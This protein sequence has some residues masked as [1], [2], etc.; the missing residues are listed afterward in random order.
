MA[1]SSFVRSWCSMYSSRT[2]SFVEIIQAS[3]SLFKLY[4]NEIIILFAAIDLHF[5]DCKTI[6]NLQ[7]EY[8][9]RKIALY[10]L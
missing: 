7:E 6:Y 8:S 5:L 4:F 2:F 1:N 9:D 3:I 10:K